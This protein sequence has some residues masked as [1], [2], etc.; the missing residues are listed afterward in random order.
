ML[1]G[2]ISGFVMTVI[3]LT[4]IVGIILMNQDYK[5][6]SLKEEIDYL[7]KLIKEKYNGR[8]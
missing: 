4:I 7:N 5:I 1:G 8:N 2:L 6:D 3:L